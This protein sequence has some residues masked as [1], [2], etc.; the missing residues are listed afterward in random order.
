[1]PTEIPGIN[2]LI[3]LGGTAIVAQSNATLTTSLEL[4]EVVNKSTNFTSNLSGDQ[5]W[6]LSHEGQITDD[7]SEHLLTDGNA[8]LKVEDNGLTI[9]PGLQDLTIT[10]E[11]ELSEV[12]PGLDEPV[13]WK[14]YVPLRRSWTVEATGH[15][16]DPENDTTYSAIHT[17]RDS[18]TSLDAELTVA[19]ITMAGKIAA[20]SME[21]DAGTDDPAEYS[22]SFTGDGAL[23]RS[24]TAQSTIDQLLTGY[25]D[26]SALTVALRHME[27]GTTI[28]QSTIWTG[29]AYL[30]SAT[31]ELERSEQ[32]SLSAEL[33]GDG[34]LTR[35]TFTA[36]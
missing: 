15:Y 12:P 11:Q 6:T 23:T 27:G 30:S 28:D 8:S 24:G 5:E 13:G 4:A 10:L 33:Q 18:G 36:T 17:A 25:F 9:V 31:I 22:L 7:A 3:T 1:M 26:Q 35:D 21:I 20:D 19:G 2:M 29:D 34:A 32:P 16:Y 14:G